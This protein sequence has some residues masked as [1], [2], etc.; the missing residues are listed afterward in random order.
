MIP[1]ARGSAGNIPKQKRRSGKNGERMRLDVRG[2]CG[3][4]DRLRFTCQAIVLTPIILLTTVSC[5]T[6]TSDLA[7][8]DLYSGLVTEDPRQL[9]LQG[10][11]AQK[12]RREQPKTPATPKVTPVRATSGSAPSDAPKKANTP[13]QRD[14]QKEKELFKEFLEWKR[15][16][17]L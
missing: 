8:C 5:S 17:E 2:R 10:E 9:V 14:L 6:L 7:E 15:Q 11:A 4:S 12:A 1:P 16:T 3:G 13:P